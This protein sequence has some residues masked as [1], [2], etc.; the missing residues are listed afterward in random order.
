MEIPNTENPKENEFISENNKTTQN[1]TTNSMNYSYPTIKKFIINENIDLSLTTSFYSNF[2]FNQKDYL[3]LLN[4]KCNHGLTG[5]KNLGNTSYLNSIIQCLSNTPELVYYYISDKFLDDIKIPSGTN[6]N[7]QKKYGSI[8]KNFSIILKKLW[9]ESNKIINPIE[10]KYSID[11]KISLYKG[12]V[13]HDSQEFLLIFLNLLHEEVNRENIIGLNKYYET[14]KIENESDIAASKRFWNFF[15][16]ENNSILIDLF[17]GQ[18]KNTIKCLNC[19]HSEINFETFSVLSLEIPNLKKISVLLVPSN[20]IKNN[21]EIDLFISDQAL[22]IDIGVY[23]KQYICSGFDNLRVLVYNYNN[24]SVKFVKMSENIFNASKKGMIVIYEISDYI[25]NSDELNQENSLDSNEEENNNEN[26]NENENN[27][28]NDNNNNYYYDYFPFITLIKFKNFDEEKDKYIDNHFRSFPRVFP[29]NSYN[30]IKNFRSKIL[31]YLRKYYPLPNDLK[32]ILNDNYD[33]IIDN[34][35]NKNI[36]I[37]EIEL[38]NIYLKEYNLLFN[39]NYQKK[40]N[41][42]EEIKNSI[43]NYL[44]NFPFKIFLVSNKE[45]NEDKLFFNS[46]FEEYSKE[47]KDTDSIDKIINY[48]RN[49]YKLVLYI[50]NKDLIDNFNEIIKINF[51]NEKEKEK[52]DLEE[53]NNNNE[54]DEEENNNENE[55]EKTPTLNDIF[56]HFC[57]HEKL[58]KENEWFCPNCKKLVNAYK[59]LDLFY[60]PRILMLSIKR[61]QRIY[62]SKTK[63]QLLKKNNLVLFPKS[64][65]NLDKFVL[66]PKIPNNIYDLY[67]VNQH[68]GSNEGGHYATAAKNFGKWY[69]FDD[70]AVFDCDDDMICTSEGYLLFYRRKSEETDKKKNNNNNN[71]NDDDKNKNN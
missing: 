38:N 36:D 34:Y 29:I 10:L 47:F 11:D 62:L 13:Q 6:K 67:S 64:N 45:N 61:Y 65:M 15:K 48:I 66:G 35:N 8:S 54:N 41:I 3:K 39:E 2:T 40:L 20:N 60:L 9:L 46:N 49:G 70:Q 5:L 7:A 50:T 26:E 43:K 16:K 25:S 32:N 55:V 19:A 30:K 14:N 21:I 37:D 4:N 69:M 71:N 44:N 33:N 27:N 59:K 63:V 68:S 17:Y 51:K 22:F 23:L 53:D 1:S 28:N 42:N 57:L 52:E 31:G 56:I 58:D 24:S 18:I 12:N